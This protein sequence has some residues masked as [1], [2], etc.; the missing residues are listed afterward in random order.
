MVI[1]SLSL[2][3]GISERDFGEYETG[4]NM[5]VDAEPDDFVD[6]VH[7]THV[8]ECIEIHPD[9][10]NSDRR[11]RTAVENVVIFGHWFELRVN[12][13]LLVQQHLNSAGSQV[14]AS[15]EQNRASPASPDTAFET[16]DS[17]LCPS[18]GASF[19][20][21]QFTLCLPRPTGAASNLSRSD[22]VQLWEENSHSDFRLE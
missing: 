2:A 20:P 9:D 16:T 17:S 10:C 1:A 6:V 8:E 14:R 4:K 7:R 5:K 19:R 3:A 12:S 22:L 21:V 18:R 15:G 13:F 11:E